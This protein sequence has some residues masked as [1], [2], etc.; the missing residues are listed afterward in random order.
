MSLLQGKVSDQSGTPAWTVYHV[1]PCT[2]QHTSQSAAQST[3][4]LPA[5]VPGNGVSRGGAVEGGAEGGSEAAFV[6]ALTAELTHPATSPPPSLLDLPV[7]DLG[8]GGS[9][10]SHQAQ[11]PRTGAVQSSTRPSGLFYMR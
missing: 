11:E 9:E 3:E 6:K 2:V 5:A 8:A 1:M 4:G 7:A 10:S